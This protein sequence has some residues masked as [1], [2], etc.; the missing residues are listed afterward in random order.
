MRNKSAKT[1]GEN[2]RICWTSLTN[3]VTTTNDIAQVSTDEHAWES[4]CTQKELPFGGSFDV[5]IVN[6]AGDDSPRKDTVGESDKIV[7]EPDSQA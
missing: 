1:V 6:D 4:D 7:Q 2:V 3:R 5:T